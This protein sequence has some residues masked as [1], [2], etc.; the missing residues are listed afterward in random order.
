MGLHCFQKQVI[1]M[2]HRKQ[3]KEEQINFWMVKGYGDLRLEGNS[4]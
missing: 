1:S 3:R 2:Y 4:V